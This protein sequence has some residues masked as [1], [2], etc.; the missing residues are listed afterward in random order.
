LRS[1]AARWAADN[2]DKLT[3]PD[4][5]I[6]EALNDRAADNW[7]PLLAIAELAGGKWPT[8]GREAACILSGE[9]S[10][11]MNVELLADIRL[12]FGEEQD[13][14]RSADLVA[15]LT[16]NPERPWVEW[17][18]GKPLSQKQLGSLLRPFGIVSVKIDMPGEPQARGY[19]RAHFEGAWDAYCPGQ[20][21][22]Q[23]HSDLPIRPK[24]PEGPST[25]NKFDVFEVSEKGSSDGS[26]NANL[27]NN[28]AVSDTS[29]GSK[30][31]N[32]TAREFDHRN[33]PGRQ[34]NPLRQK[35]APGVCDHCKR[36]G[37]TVRASYAGQAE[38][39]LHP[40]CEDEWRAAQPLWDLAA[41]I[42]GSSA[43]GRG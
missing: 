12:A 43:A 7:R 38:V 5:A 34:V 10:A 20:N 33:P 19:R 28:H 9:G 15:K 6:P 31:G 41:A 14:I 39:D 22:V 24:C 2:F 13:V 37:A 35:L 36:P 27:S 17:S 18:H 21:R 8:Q 23:P 3:D 4:P 1:K 26:K 30:P 29:D 25:L 11:S 42:R 40:G 16:E 32:G